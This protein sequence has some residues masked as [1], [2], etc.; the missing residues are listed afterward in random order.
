MQYISTYY[1]M[2]IKDYFWYVDDTF[3]LFK[4]LEVKHKKE[5]S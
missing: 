5:Y 2:Y 1:T 3:I 4:A